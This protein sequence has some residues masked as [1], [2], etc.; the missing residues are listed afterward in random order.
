MVCYGSPKSRPGD[1]LSKS[2]G[3]RLSSRLLVIAMVAAGL[4]GVE[5]SPAFAYTQVDLAVPTV[6]P[7]TESSNELDLLSITK[8]WTAGE[9]RHLIGVLAVDSSSDTGIILG[10]ARVTCGSVWG[11]N[12]TQNHPGNIEQRAVF[13]TATMTLTVNWLW[14]AP[15]DGTY[16]C[17]LYVRAVPQSHNPGDTL[18]ALAGGQTHLWM[19]GTYYQGSGIWSTADSC[20]YDPPACDDPA[21]PHGI[22]IG[23]GLPANEAEYVLHSGRWTAAATTTQVR[24]QLDAELTGCYYGT[25]SCPQSDWGPQSLSGKP[26]KGSY[27]PVITIYS[28]STGQVCRTINGTSRTFYDSAQIHHLKIN[29]TTYVSLNAGEDCR[30]FSAKLYI[31]VDPTLNPIKVESES[32]SDG[33]ILNYAHV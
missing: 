21:D 2:Y 32:Y 27:Y 33:I 17:H 26:S 31:A 15:A 28:A 8:S 13:G 19:T 16:T 5:V 4:V 3:R 11:V 1:R 29:S 7:V 6:V 14:R 24:L 30:Q 18:T 25:D 12:T 22:F 20:T 9:E 23:A 10:V